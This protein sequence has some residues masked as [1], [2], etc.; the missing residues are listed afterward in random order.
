MNSIKNIGRVAGLLYLFIDIFALVSML[1]VPTDPSHA[2]T[3]WLAINSVLE[4]L[5]GGREIV[6]GI[7]ILLITWG[8]LLAKRLPRALNYLGLAVGVAGVLTV[9]PALEV[10]AIGFGL[11][12]I[13]WAVWL[14]IVIFR[15]SQSAA[16]RKLRAFFRASDVLRREVGW[17]LSSGARS[18][19]AREGP[20]VSHGVNVLHALT[21]RL[22]PEE[23]PTSSASGRATPAFRRCGRGGTAPSVE[24]STR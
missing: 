5:V 17:R 3:V 11:G 24:A 8:A 13:V 23:E 21:C 12:E 6:G 1:Y 9:V 7:W 20:V 4:E 10:L 16:A 22:R 14:G 18:V 2:A 15:G 19:L